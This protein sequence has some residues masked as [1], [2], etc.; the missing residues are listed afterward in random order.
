MGSRDRPS[1][2]IR[3]TFPIWLLAREPRP[4]RA[5]RQPAV[6]PAGRTPQMRRGTRRRDRRRIG[7][8]PET[9][10]PLFSGVSRQLPWARLLHKGGTGMDRDSSREPT[11]VRVAI[12]GQML[13]GD[14]GVPPHP[15]GIVV[16]AHGSGSS[17]HSP[18][19]QFVARSL[20]RDGF[21]TLLID[22]LTHA[23]EAVDSRTAEYRFD[24]RM[25][26]ERLV[27]I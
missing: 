18:R 6:R 14:L 10:L 19:N 22:L 8:V 15:N 4:I 9:S 20:E 7:T 23:E 24:I 13:D 12:G 3:S 16:F 1:R 27:A 5:S 21:A 25:L 11:S 17:R 26:A 2:R